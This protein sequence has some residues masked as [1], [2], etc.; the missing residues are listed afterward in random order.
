[1]KK[2]CHHLDETK[3]QEIVKKREKKAAEKNYFLDKLDEGQYT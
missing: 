3:L 1:V 2:F